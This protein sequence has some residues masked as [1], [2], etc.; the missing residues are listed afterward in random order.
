[1]DGF[2]LAGAGTDFEV[3]VFGRLGFT[4]VSFFFLASS[5][6][7]FFCLRAGLMVTGSPLALSG[8]WLL[9]LQIP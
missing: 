6:A 8:T 4:G 3:I 9:C 1:M 5:G 7:D 2:H